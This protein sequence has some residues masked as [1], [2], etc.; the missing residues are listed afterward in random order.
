MTL[1]INDF[2]AIDHLENHP[3]MY[4]TDSEFNIHSDS[5]ADDGIRRLCHN[6]H[7]P[8]YLRL[9]DDLSTDETMYLQK[10]VKP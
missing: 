7:H 2:S 8:L 9:Y 3:R 5:Y 6:L 10:T 4:F 1:F